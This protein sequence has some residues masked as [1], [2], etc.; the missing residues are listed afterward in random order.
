MAIDMRQLAREGARARIAE[1]LTEL[2]E[3]R[4]AFP[5]ADRRRAA[6]G[7]TAPRRRGRRGM[8]P[9]ERKAVGIRMKAYWAAR[10]K[11]AKG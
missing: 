1:L 4:R 7:A 11:A 10:R 3:I 9:A 5:D 2:A 8:S 6:R